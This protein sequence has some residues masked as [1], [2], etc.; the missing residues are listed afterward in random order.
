MGSPLLAGLLRRRSAPLETALPRRVSVRAALCP[1]P[2]D[3]ASS[4]FRCSMPECVQVTVTDG[5][6]VQAG[7]LNLLVENQAALA[8][9]S[10]RCALGRPASG[11]EPVYLSEV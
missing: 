4:G 5:R 9:G 11:S 3:P 1:R 7:N 10:H 6:G 8:Q 2:V